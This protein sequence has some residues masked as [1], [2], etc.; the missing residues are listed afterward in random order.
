MTYGCMFNPHGK[1]RPGSVGRLVPGYDVRLVDDEGNAVPS[2]AAG[3]LLVK[4]PTMSPYYWNLPEKSAE[5]M[6]AD[7]YFRTGDVFVERD[8]YYC[9]GRSDD[10][11]KSGANWVSPV[12]VE[13][14][15]LSHPAVAECAV[16]AIHEG[17][18]CQTRSL[19]DS[20]P[21]GS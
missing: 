2:G 18:T 14:A 8:G 21:R 15:L 1:A 20:C 13:D 12:R 9:Q 19:R 7:G 17:T 3:N 16:A 6:L 10:M 4:G 11:I 5:T